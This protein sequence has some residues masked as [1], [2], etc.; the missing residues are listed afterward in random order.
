MLQT[1]PGRET[2]ALSHSSARHTLTACRAY[3]G[4][5]ETPAP[6]NSVRGDTRSKMLNCSLS[7]RIMAETKVCDKDT[8]AIKT[9][10]RFTR[11]TKT[12]KHSAINPSQYWRD[13]ARK[14]RG[15]RACTLGVLQRTL[16]ATQALAR[17]STCHGAIRQGISCLQLS[18]LSR[19]R[20]WPWSLS[21]SYERG[22]S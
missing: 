22:C 17:W 6:K 2:A 19:S 4:P 14:G 10:S 16:G 20:R 15:Y 8:F 21:L 11:A 3:A 12:Q 7:N 9:H 18:E 1:H 5:A 13:S